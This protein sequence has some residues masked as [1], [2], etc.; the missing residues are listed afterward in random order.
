[1]TAI[2]P[3]VLCY[4]FQLATSTKMEQLHLKWHGR[5]RFAQQPPIAGSASLRLRASGLAF[6]GAMSLTRE[7][8][9]CNPERGP[10]TW[11]KDTY[12]DPPVEMPTPGKLSRAMLLGLGELPWSAPNGSGSCSIFSVVCSKMVELDF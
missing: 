8:F 5:C 7:V 9:T 2:R 1:M 11:G 12:L 10:V 4:M 6:L 3:H